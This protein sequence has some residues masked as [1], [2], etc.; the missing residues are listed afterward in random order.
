MDYPRALDSCPEDRGLGVRDCA[1]PRS[2]DLL[3][4]EDPGNEVDF[5]HLW[6]HFQ[7]PSSHSRYIWSSLCMPDHFIGSIQQQIP[8]S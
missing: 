3:G 2:Q 7:Q 8:W 5:R 4:Q 6:L 1:Q